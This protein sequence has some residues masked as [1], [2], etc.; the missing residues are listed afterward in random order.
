[1]R[2]TTW[3][4][5]IRVGERGPEQVDDQLVTE[6]PLEIRLGT[7]PLAVLMRTPGDDADLVLGFAI[8]EGIVL[9][10][11][12]VAGVEAVAGDPER[13]RWELRLADGVTVDPEQFRRNLYTS[14]SCGV[15]GK[16][17]IDALTIA[18]P[19]PPPGPALSAEVL[20][21]LP[22]RME[23]SQVTFAATGG[24]HAAAVF[25]GDGTLLVLRED[26][27]RHNAVDK[28]IGALARERWPIGETVLIVS[29]RVSFEITQKA[30]V[31][32]IPVIGGVSAASSLAV[33]LGEELGLTVVGFLRGESFNIYSGEQRVLTGPG[34]VGG[35]G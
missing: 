30:A 23:G 2:R 28:A 12:E 26:V 13:N 1:M 20:L 11:D 17:S 34:G 21:G 33:E 6:A 9:S 18:A 32:G 4:D 3:R 27:G 35:L 19:T 29:G 10:P 5:V 25:D 14:S 22:P 16:A 7:T 15:C 8:T 24:Q 31:A